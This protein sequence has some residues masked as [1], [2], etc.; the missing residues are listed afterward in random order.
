MVFLHHPPSSSQ[1]PLLS[2][3]GAELSDESADQQG[4][5]QKNEAVDFTQEIRRGA[6]SADRG[7]GAR[8]AGVNPLRRTTKLRC[9][10]RDRNRCSS[11]LSSPLEASF[12]KPTVSSS[13]VREKFAAL[14]KR[15]R[16]RMH[17][18]DSTLR[19]YIDSH[20]TGWIISA[21]TKKKGITDVPEAH[22]KRSVGQLESSTLSEKGVEKRWSFFSERHKGMDLESLH[23][24]PEHRVDRQS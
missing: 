22:V 14:T 3:I 17:T 6:S 13:T 15:S 19:V 1:G 20:T 10:K 23:V 11:L 5:H 7:Q 24:A 18:Q 9:S 21:K 2:K 12:R 16:P 4:V 8:R